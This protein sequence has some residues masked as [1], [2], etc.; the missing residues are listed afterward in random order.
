MR[1]KVLGVG[2]S[3][4]FTERMTFVDKQRIEFTHEPPPGVSEW[5]GAEGRYELSDVEGGT[6]LAID[7]HLAVDMPLSRLATPVVTRTMQATMQMM[8]DRFTA[9]LLRELDAQQR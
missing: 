1:L 8:G 2:I 5:A 7:L 6:N 3:P 9:N 4:V